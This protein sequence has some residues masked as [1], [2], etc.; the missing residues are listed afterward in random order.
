MKLVVET[1]GTSTGHTTY[2]Y[3]VFKFLKFSSFLSKVLWLQK[4]V[5]NGIIMTSRNDLQKFYKVVILGKTPKL[6]LI[7]APKMV[8][9][10][11]TEQ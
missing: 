1:T 9:E 3:Q 6:L 10:S 2:K 8:R 7:K 5:E 11:T 4:K